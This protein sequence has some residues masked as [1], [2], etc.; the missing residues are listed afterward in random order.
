MVVHAARTPNNPTGIVEMP[1]GKIKMIQLDQLVAGKDEVLIGFG[2]PRVF[3]VVPKAD[4][5]GYQQ[6]D[7][8][9]FFKRKAKVADADSVQSGV[10]IRPRNLPADAAQ[11]L[12]DA[13]SHVAG[14]RTLSTA[15]ANAETLADAGSL[16]AARRFPTR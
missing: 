1:C 2:L 12:R 6:L 7:A 9:A 15:H 4:G 13:I 5:K 10:F 3:T 11:S 8:R 16:P 14:H